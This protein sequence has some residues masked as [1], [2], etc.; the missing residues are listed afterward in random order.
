[1]AEAVGA[2][3]VG[4]G[5]GQTLGQ[6]AAG[7]TANRAAIAGASCCVGEGSSQTAGIAEAV[8]SEEKS[9]RADRA[10]SGV[11]TDVAIA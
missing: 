5:A 10:L 7:R 1:M 4:G 9:C 11:Y 8:A 2:K 3:E 6:A